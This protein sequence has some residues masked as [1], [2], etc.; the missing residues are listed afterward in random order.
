MYS[1]ATCASCYIIRHHSLKH[2][3]SLCSSALSYLTS[4]SITPL[5]LSSTDKV[6]DDYFAKS[7]DYFSIYVLLNL[8]VGFNSG[9]HQLLETV[10][11]LGFH[12]TMFSCFA[13][14]TFGYSWS[15]LV[16]SSTP[17]LNIGV[18]QSSFQG[19]SL[20]NTSLKW[21]HPC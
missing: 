7:K 8:S 14:S 10:S 3:L 1:I 12:D 5:I 21:V 11:S 4:T 20:N 2:S 19:S 17:P 13:F 6:T 18:S 15:P 16:L 9:N